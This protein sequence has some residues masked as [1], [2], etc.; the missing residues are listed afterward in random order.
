[1][2]IK[3]V[4]LLQEKCIIVANYDRRSERRECFAF[5]VELNFFGQRSF[6]FI[7]QRNNNE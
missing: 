2:E 6:T 3:L 5:F 4:A 1:M 7:K